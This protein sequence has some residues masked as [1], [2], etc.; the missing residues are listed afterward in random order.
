MFTIQISQ[1]NDLEFILGL[2]RDAVKY[3]KEKG[4]NLWPEFE[5]SLIEKEIQGQ[6]HYK[7]TESGKIACVFSVLYNDPIIWEEKDKDPAI[8]LH[9]I[10]TNPKFK[11]KG[12]MQ[13]ITN[14]AHEHAVQHQKN[15]IRMDTWGD[16][17]NLKNYY[18]N[19]GFQH[20]GQV[21]LPENHE[22]PSHYWG[23]TL[24]L[25]EIKI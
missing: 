24:S 5:K 20:M 21:S 7:I 6:S 22:L 11:G 19:F 13:L 1:P 23:S 12:M 16:N 2:Y 14:W 18:I 9:R 3:Q 8:Y 17:E 15:Y 4:Y 10:A 25:F